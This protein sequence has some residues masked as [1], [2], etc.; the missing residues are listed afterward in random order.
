MMSIGDF[1]EANLGESIDSL[2][3]LD[4]K[5][6]GLMPSLYQA[7]RE[8][9]GG[10]LVLEAARSLVDVAEPNSNVLICTGFRAHAWE[11][12]ETDGVIGAVVLARALEVSL[13]VHPVIVCE[14]E[15][16]DAVKGLVRVSGLHPDTNCEE[17]CGFPHSV[18]ICS[19][20]KDE[21]AAPKEAKEMLGLFRPVA[22]VSVERPGKNSK[23]VYHSMGGA[24]VSEFTS[25]IDYLFQ[26]R[27]EEILTIAIGD[28]GNELGLG[29]IRNT[30][31]KVLMYG[32]ECQ[33]PCKGG[34]AC[35]VD[36]DKIIIA[37]VSDWGAYGLGAEVAFLTKKPEAFHDGGMEDDLLQTAARYGLVSD[38]S[39]YCRPG[40]DSIGKDF[41]VSFVKILR[42][43]LDHAHMLRTRPP[44]IY[45]LYSEMR[46][47]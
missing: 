11:N 19:F 41:H 3:T 43:M 4:V 33:C 47:K 39:G 6:Q 29:K 37:L 30:T 44:R 5:S 12:G 28:L 35:A 27:S 36:A 8:L 46:S 21:H 42:T 13:N 22:L 2:I 17:S 14:S 20:T 26:L 34:I 23:G 18:K 7:A 15:L 45:E 10:P 24:D 25:K 31:R 32:K 1:V 16:V 40:I 38:S 9:I